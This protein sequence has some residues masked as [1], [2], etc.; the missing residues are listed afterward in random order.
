MVE[1][2]GK[3]VA[4]EGV[5]VRPRLGTLEVALPLFHRIAPTG[6]LKSCRTATEGFRK[7][8]KRV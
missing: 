3:H 7:I 4:T 1:G 6:E 8:H 2:P 5:Q